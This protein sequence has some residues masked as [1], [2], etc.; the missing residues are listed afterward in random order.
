M[1]APGVHGNCESRPPK[2]PSSL[3]GGSLISKT[4]VLISEGMA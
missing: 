4:P 2:P 1:I 3:A